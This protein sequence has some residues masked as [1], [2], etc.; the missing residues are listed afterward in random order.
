LSASSTK[1]YRM[2]RATRGV[3]EGTWYYEIVVEQ[4]GPTGHTRL[5][6]STQ[7]GDVQAPVGFDSNSYGYRDLD[8]SKTHVAV[9]E[10]Y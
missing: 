8:G 6:W 2:V 1:G 3:Q 10:T 9:R 7:K 5:G 4:L